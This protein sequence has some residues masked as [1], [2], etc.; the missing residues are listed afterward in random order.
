MPEFPRRPY[1]IKKEIKPIIGKTVKRFRFIHSS[2]LKIQFTD[3]SYLVID[4]LECDLDY[5]FDS[6]KD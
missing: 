5:W 2:V 1:H 4:G 3:D 6:M